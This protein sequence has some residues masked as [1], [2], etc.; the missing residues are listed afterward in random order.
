MI[1]EHLHPKTWPTWIGLGIFRL[2]IMLPYRRIMQAGRGI[3]RIIW[4]LLPKKRRHV[5]NRNL[6]RCFPQLS[7]AQR[8][9]LAQQHIEA[10]GQGFLE[11][12]LAWWGKDRAL[13]TLAH[14]E[15]LQHLK[16][17]QA[18]GKGVILL[19][20]HFTSLEIG[21]RLLALN[22]P[23]HVM[24]RPSDNAAIEFLMQRNRTHHFENAIRK[25]DIKGLIRSLRQGHA[26]WYAPDQ[27]SGKN[28]S[29]FA[30]FFGIETATNTATARLVKLTGAPVV[31]FLPL[32]RKDGSG[33]DLTIFPALED[34]PAGDERQDARRINAIFEAW[35]RQQPQD[36]FWFHRRF[37]MQPPGEPDFY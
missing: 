13:E 11:V 2:I 17:A 28:N 27:S 37:K 21:G 15:G 19:S 12:A 36:Y 32:R 31:P 29:V 8:N 7:G 5:L 24:Y 35:A 30:P 1:P 3:G 6:E 16:N 22:T 25:D 33:Y 18:L 23:F 4:H 34:F 9:Q 14:L 26:I 10:M 20:A